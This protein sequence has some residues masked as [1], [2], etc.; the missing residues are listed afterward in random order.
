MSV[1][2]IGA[3]LRLGKSCTTR[4]EGFRAEREATVKTGR[5]KGVA[6]ERVEERCCHGDAARDAC[7]NTSAMLRVDE[8]EGSR[9][10]VPR[11]GGE[12]KTIKEKSQA[13]TAPCWPGGL[14]EHHK[15]KR[16]ILKKQQ[17]KEVDTGQKHT[18]GKYATIAADACASQASGRVW[19]ATT[20]KD[21]ARLCS[22]TCTENVSGKIAWHFAICTYREVDLKSFI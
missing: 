5:M 17:G 18:L 7:R 9:A 1:I 20:H 6:W 10:W 13:K 2:V 3:R 14:L 8:E 21:Q 15:P 16:H 11:E 12:E 19:K 4:Q 22:R